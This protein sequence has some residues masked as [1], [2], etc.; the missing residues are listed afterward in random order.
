MNE[1]VYCLAALTATKFNKIFS[2]VQS[3]LYSDD[4]FAGLSVLYRS[5]PKHFRHLEVYTHNR[6]ILAKV[7]SQTTEHTVSAH[8]VNLYSKQKGP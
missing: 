3:L 1:Y 8:T 4:R 7:C 5:K 6:T 2:N